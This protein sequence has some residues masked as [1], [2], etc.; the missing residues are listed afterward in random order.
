VVSQAHF[1]VGGGC[2]DDEFADEDYAYEYE[3]GM[4]FDNHLSDTFYIKPSTAFISN[5]PDGMAFEWVPKKPVYV[6]SKDDLIKLYESFVNYLETTHELCNS[7][8]GF[9]PFGVDLIL[10][11]S[12][13][14]YSETVEPEAAEPQNI[15][16][17]FDVEHFR[18]EYTVIRTLNGVFRYAELP[19]YDETPFPNTPK[20]EKEV[21]KEILKDVQTLIKKLTALTKM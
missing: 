20:C 11:F 13:L 9:K 16:V 17:L 2:Y 12:D 19:R 3:L 5:D 21:Q 4:V 18:P 7:W 15:N 8:H 14:H 6:T 1:S 10:C